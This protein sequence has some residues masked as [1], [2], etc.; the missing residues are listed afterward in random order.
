MTD[1]YAYIDPDYHYSNPKTGVLKNLAGIDN[2]KKLTDFESLCVTIRSMSLEK[3][4]S[5]SGML[6][7]Y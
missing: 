2:H 7:F 4:I 1:N 6:L 3:L 5:L